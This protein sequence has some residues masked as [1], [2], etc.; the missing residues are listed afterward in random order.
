M[1]IYFAAKLNNN[2]EVISCYVDIDLT[3]GDIDYMSY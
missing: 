1:P 2:D 3:Y